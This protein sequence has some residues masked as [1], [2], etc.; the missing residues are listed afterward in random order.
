[1]GRFDLCFAGYLSGI[2]IA[3]SCGTLALHEQIS[4]LRWLGITLIAGGVGFVAGGEALTPHSHH[5]EDGS[6]ERNANGD[7][8]AAMGA[9]R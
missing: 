6:Y 3:G 5:H 9:D 1:M 4:I 2:R 7:L 8:P